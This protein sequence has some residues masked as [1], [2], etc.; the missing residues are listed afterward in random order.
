[1]LNYQRVTL[2]NQPPIGFPKKKM[3]VALLSSKHL[4][5]N[6][7]TTEMEK[8][9]FFNP[10]DLLSWWDLSI[11]HYNYAEISPH[12]WINYKKSPKIAGLF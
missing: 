6:H 2:L 9:C 12:I 11:N 1:M 8:R 5:L 4:E 7:S 3:M 10:K